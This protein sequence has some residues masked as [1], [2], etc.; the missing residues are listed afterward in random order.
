MTIKRTKLIYIKDGFP[1]NGWIQPCLLCNNPT[2]KLYNY[3]TI[4]KYGTYSLT[5]TTYDLELQIY[6]C[7]KCCD[8]CKKNRFVSKNYKQFIDDYIIKYQLHSFKPPSTQTL[9]NL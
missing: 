8:K 2:S 3:T 5:N 9:R 4:K 7:E 6:M 1:E